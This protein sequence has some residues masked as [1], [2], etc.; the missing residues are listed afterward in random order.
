[1]LNSV[2]NSATRKLCK[3]TAV[4][5]SRCSS[6]APR[7]LRKA[8]LPSHTRRVSARSNSFWNRNGSRSLGKPVKSKLCTIF[9]SEPGF[10][11]SRSLPEEATE[12]LSSGDD[13]EVDAVSQNGAVSEQ[14]AGNPKVGKVAELV[15]WIAGAFLFGGAITLIQGPEKG[16]EFFAGYLL[17]ESLSVDN[18]FVFVL[19]F[20]YFEVPLASQSRVLL[21]GIWGA[22]IMRAIMVVLGS[23]AIEN[24]QPVLLVF[25][26][27][28]IFSSY[29]LLTEGEGEDEDFSENAILKFC[30]RFIPVTDEMDGDR[31]F[32][33]VKEGGTVV[34]KATPLLLVLAVVEL[35][36][37]VFAVDSIPAVFGVTQDPFIV[38]TSNMFAIFGLRS[39][40]YFV[41]SAVEDLV[42]LQPAVALVLGFVGTKMVGE[43]CG[44]EV[45]TEASLAVVA[46]L[47]AGGIGLS[48][49]PSDLLPFNTGDTD[50]S[51]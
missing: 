13:L 31:F 29:K 38:Y 25:A 43:Y 7:E 42:Y 47:L 10:K 15:F 9:R 19:I 20:N 26:G 12:P 24:F 41:S 5:N 22:A 11:V 4:S 49:L 46:T 28:L 34:T 39:L 27:I 35:S 30:K 37:V 32:T 21:Y 16:S 23:A 48:L 36:D 1:M 50:D 18:L 6:C 44:L 3:R 8:P 2:T 40:Y 14:D 17:E 33:E 45:S 51:D